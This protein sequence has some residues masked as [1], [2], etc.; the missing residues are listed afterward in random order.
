VTLQQSK[1]SGLS[2]PDIDLVLQPGTLGRQFTTVEGIL[3]QVY[4]ELSKKVFAGD[5]SVGEGPDGDDRKERKKALKNFCITERG[6]HSY[7]T[8]T[9]VKKIILSYVPITPR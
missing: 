4:E 3:E 7:F 2:I 1:T 6:A 5:S 9:V 8:G